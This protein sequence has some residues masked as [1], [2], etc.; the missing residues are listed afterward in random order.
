MIIKNTAALATTPLRKSA[1][2]ILE[3]GFAALNTEKIM[4]EAI[5]LEGNALRILDHVID[6]SPY[7]GVVVLGFGKA[8]V[9]MGTAIEDILGDRITA[10]Y[11]LDRKP[12]KFRIMKHLLASHPNPT[13]GNAMATDEIIEF[14]K[15]VDRKA[16]IIV[17]ISGGGSAML[18][19]PYKI[20]VEEKAALARTLMDAG[21]NIQ[22]L[23]I[24]RKHL[25][26]IKGGRIVQYV[27][28]A[29]VVSVIL[30]DVIGNDLSTIASGPTVF[31]PTTIDDAKKVLA[32]YKLSTDLEFSESP[33]D[34]NLFEHV[35]NILI[36]D[37]RLGIGPMEKKVKALGYVPSVVS[38]ELSG[39]AD[40]IGQI[41]L[42]MVRPGQ[43]LIAAGETTLEVTGKGQGGRNQQLVLSSLP[44][45]RDGQVL[46]S[47]NT[48]GHDNS[49][50]AGA[51]G[52]LETINKAG[53]KKLD[54]V[55]Y[56][57]TNDSYA[58]FKEVGD[59][60]VTGELE[61]NFADL[62]LCLSEKR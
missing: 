34:K 5:R 28:P 10:G 58:F 57:E 4:K 41:L 44:K 24:V 46:L 49:D 59:H 42:S 11:I 22:E 23:N 18:T 6:L 16:L 26:R 47:V 20:S 1:L 9:G 37:V 48:D 21:A 33:K 25:S 39:E 30:S 27:Y 3:A 2:E 62:M 8:A 55:K 17:L 12:G 45:I 35:E 52:D 31:D 54:A 14:L 40:K 15:H 43:V 7:S 51:L 38:S 56:A 53:A 29:K 13:E 61:S 50:V 36:G 19:A 60:I 32:K